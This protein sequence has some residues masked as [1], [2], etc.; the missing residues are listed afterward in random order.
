[1]P[2]LVTG[3]DTEPFTAKIRDYLRPS[4]TTSPWRRSVPESH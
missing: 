4:P 1:M 2:E 3:T